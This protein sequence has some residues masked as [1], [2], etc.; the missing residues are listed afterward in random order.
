MEPTNT[1]VR[2]Q[3][4]SGKRSALSF[5]LGNWMGFEALDSNALDLDSIF[6][7]WTVF[8]AI[9]TVFNSNLTV[10]PFNWEK[11]IE[12][13]KIFEIKTNN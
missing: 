9:W 1:C 8:G 10:Y 3:G 13:K 4:F 5:F 7:Y 11:A 12:M 2:R 6:V